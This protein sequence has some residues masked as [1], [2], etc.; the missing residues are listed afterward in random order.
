MDDK[1]EELYKKNQIISDL[2]EKLKKANNKLTEK[3]NEIKN[4]KLNNEKLNKEVNELKDKL[5][6]YPFELLEGEEML[7]VNFNS[8]DDNIHY[9]VI[10]KNT[11]KF[12][13]LEN[14]LHDNFPNYFE[15]EN[16]FTIKGV[17]IDRFKKLQDYNIRNND[18][19]ILNKVSN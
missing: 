10:C 7:N 2:R 11:D 17:K 1:K 8:A 6:R 14:Q 19:I 4:L 5:A 15:T 3:N 18:I 9:S 13:V 12:Y 16:Y